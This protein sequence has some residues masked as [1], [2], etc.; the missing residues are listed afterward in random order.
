MPAAQGALSQPRAWPLWALC[1]GLGACVGLVAWGTRQAPSE[2]WPWAW[3]GYLAASALWGLALWLMARGALGARLWA[4]LAVGLGLRLLALASAPHFSDDLWRYLWDGRVQWEGINPY[5]YA[6]S[7][8]ALTALRDAEVW[9]RINFPEVPTIYP[10]VA[11]LAFALGALLGGTPLGLRL[12][13][14]AAELVA[15]LGAWRL[16]E[17]LRPPADGPARERQRAWIAAG[18]ALSPLQVMEFGGSAHLDALAVAPLVWGLAWVAP[19]RGEAPLALRPWLWAGLC[20]GLS[21]GAK[22]LGLLALPAM[23]LWAWWPRGLGGRPDAQGRAWRRGAALLA[24][25]ALALALTAWPYTT[26]WVFGRGGSFG[27]GLSTYARKWRANDGLF[28]LGL[29]AHEASFE[30]AFGPP[31]DQDRPYW[32]L[33]FLN[34]PFRALGVTHLHEGR[35]VASTTLSRGEVALGLTKLMAALGMAWALAFSLHQR[36]T[37]SAS[38]LA[39]MTCLLLVAPTVHPWYVAWLVPLAMVHRAWS[40]LLWAALVPLAYHAAM[41]LA[42]GGVWEESVALRAL[43]YAPVVLFTL[44]ESLQRLAKPSQ[45]FDPRP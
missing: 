23:L 13:M 38:V 21:A 45:D 24:G 3:G 31:D 6:P 32:R 25:V 9:P 33:D 1:A 20:V 10:P 41:R 14:L 7:D 18:L 39:L 22:L 27:E 19:T 36:L 16:G 2:G 4:V 29:A 43:E 44:W 12:I 40:V 28:A 5:A 8:P 42:L 17:R 11:Q 34:A 15:L 26:P 30:R 37:P 35:L